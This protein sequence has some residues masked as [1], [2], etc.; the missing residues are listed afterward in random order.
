M[1][2][3][4]YIETL[5]D[6]MV[7]TRAEARK[8]TKEY[9]FLDHNDHE[10]K[11]EI[12]K[13]LFGSVGKNVAIDTKIHCDFGKNTFIGDDVVM[14]ANCTLIDNEKITIGNKVLIA[15]NLQIYTAFHP[16][17]PEERTLE[18]NTNDGKIFFN[19]CAAPVTIEDGVWTGGGVIILPG[20]TIGKNSVIGAG[21]VVTK[22]IPPNCVAVGN[23]C[24]PIKFFDDIR[25]KEKCTNI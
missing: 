21:S 13:K 3:Y 2:K 8:L 7:K 25:E 10:K 23:P 19:T 17:L 22:D 1:K 20:V 12:L 4:D 5:T 6:E 14:G 18:K 16:I 11:Y 24:R 15:P 9:F